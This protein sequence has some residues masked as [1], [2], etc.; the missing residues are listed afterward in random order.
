MAPPAADGMHDDAPSLLVQVWPELGHVETITPLAWDQ[1]IA[2]LSR[3]HC[4]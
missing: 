4:P 2:D 1:L 3:M